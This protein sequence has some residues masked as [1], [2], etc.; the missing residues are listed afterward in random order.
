[1]SAAIR[2]P[3]VT[4]V[5]D[6][7]Q[8]P[9][10]NAYFVMELLDGESLEK[11]LEKQPKLPPF[12]AVDIGL[13]ILAALEAAHARGIV[14]R[15]LKPENVWLEP[16]A[17]GP[18]VKLLDFGI[19]KLKGSAEFQSVSTRPGSM[20]GTP[21]YMAPEQAISADQVD[22]RADLYSFGVMLFEM[23][24]GVRPVDAEDPREVLER[25][26]RGEVRRLQSVTQGM[27]HG[28][29]TLVDRLV[30]PDPD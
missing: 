5:I 27:P 19:A 28:L 10:G 1:V 4:K 12:E 26:V 30:A 9:E 18:Y 13:Q 3:H 7:D 6:V 24:S 16:S 25:L 8:T 20:M 14:H 11:R 29:T 17:T 23:L 2:N 22:A 21:A 15:D